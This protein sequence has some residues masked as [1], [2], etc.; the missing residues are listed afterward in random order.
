MRNVACELFQSP[1]LVVLAGKISSM[2]KEIMQ[3]YVDGFP[4]VRRLDGKFE[5]ENLERKSSSSIK[6]EEIIVGF[7]D[8]ARV[9]LERLT[10]QNKK[11]KSY[12]NCWNGRYW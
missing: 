12:L 3:V 7:D 11:L 10:G 4:D 5:S 2:K 8:E 1:E 9:Q 6:G